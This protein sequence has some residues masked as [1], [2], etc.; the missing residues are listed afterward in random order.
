MAGTAR[1]T[2]RAGAKLNLT[3]DV[4]GVREDGHHLLQMIMQSVDLADLVTVTKGGT[5]EL[6]VESNRSYLPAGE[7]NIAGRAARAFFDA[8][9]MPLVGIKI[10]IKKGIPV[11]AGLGGGSADAA[12]VLVAL[13]DLFGNPL[14][15]GNL[16]DIALPIGADVPFCLSGGTQL[17]EGTGDILSPLPDMPP[18]CFV[19]VKPCNK[20]STRDMYRKFDSI[21]ADRRPDTERAV[22]AICG[23]DLHALAGAVYNV[24]DHVW[25]S[26]EIDRAKTILLGA[27]ALGASISGSGPTV[28]GIFEDKAEADLCADY[29]KQE[30]RPVYICRPSGTGCELLD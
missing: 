27:G 16:T 17:A 19:L 28:F 20:V 29:L 24:F 5:G 6:V 23:G 1:R 2:V 15:P 26:P 13:N 3:L 9:G 12:A 21:S 25:H 8:I 14:T 7:R 30:F 10:R 18:C 4:T 22:E 11:S